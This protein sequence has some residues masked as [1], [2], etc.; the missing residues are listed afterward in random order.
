MRYLPEDE[1]M[2]S[3]VQVSQEWTKKQGYSILQEYKGLL[4]IPNIAPDLVNTKR[5]GELLVKMFEKRGFEMQLLE[6][7]GAPPCIKTLWVAGIPDGT[8]DKSLFHV[9][10]FLKQKYEDD[11]EDRLYDANDKLCKPPVPKSAVVKIINSINSKEYYYL[12]NDQPMV[13]LCNK[14]LCAKEEFLNR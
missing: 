3:I 6:I 8:R 11:W 7:E 4:S 12:C 14:D 5:N 2:R 1:Y 10:I 9:G 13:K